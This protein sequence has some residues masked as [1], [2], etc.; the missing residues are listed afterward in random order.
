[1]LLVLLLLLLLLLSTLLL[2]FLSV[3]HHGI[4]GDSVLMC[5][6]TPDALVHVFRAK[7]S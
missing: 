2:C 3:A 4:M 1:L 5:F 7:E 6:P